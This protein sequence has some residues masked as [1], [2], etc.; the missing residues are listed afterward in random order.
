MIN[1]YICTLFCTINSD[2][3]VSHRKHLRSRKKEIEAEL[4]SVEPVIVAARAAVGDI[5]TESLSE[6]NLANDCIF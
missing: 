1:I 6:V 3:H 5:K 4:A 2:D